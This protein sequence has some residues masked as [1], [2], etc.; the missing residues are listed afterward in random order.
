PTTEER[1]T[2]DGVG[3]FRHFEGGSIYWH[4]RT[5]AHVVHGLIRQKWAELG[6][7]RS[8]LGYPTSDE[9]PLANGAG[10]YSEFQGGTIYWQAGTSNVVVR[11]RGE[12]APEF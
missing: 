9:L 1:P 8:F 7:E 12:P 10:R 6:W 3:R 2:P 4:P 11:K 5:G